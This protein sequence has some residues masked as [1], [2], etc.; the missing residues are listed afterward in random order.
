MKVNC[1]NLVHIGSCSVNSYLF[2]EKIVFFDK[3]TGFSPLFKFNSHLNVDGLLNIKLIP[4][5][6]SL[7]LKRLVFIKN[8]WGKCSR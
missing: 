1:Q 6:F 2:V 3:K 5:L 7:F 4:P 8:E